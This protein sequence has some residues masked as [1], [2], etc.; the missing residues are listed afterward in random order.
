MLQTPKAQYATQHNLGIQYRCG[1]QYVK[2]SSQSSNT[3]ELLE[4]CSVKHAYDYPLFLFDETGKSELT[5]LNTLNLL[6]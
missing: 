2:H 6:P 1:W 3:L 5:T 4:H